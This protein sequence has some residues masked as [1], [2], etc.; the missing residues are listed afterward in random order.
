MKSDNNFG[1]SYVV[2]VLHLLFFQE[3][4]RAKL[5]KT[6][7][8]VDLDDWESVYKNLICFSFLFSQTVS[9][10]EFEN[11]WN[12]LRSKSLPNHKISTRDLKKILNKKCDTVPFYE[13]SNTLWFFTLQLIRAMVR[14]GRR[15]VFFLSREGEFLKVLFDDAVRQLGLDTY[16]NS[17]YLMVS[18]RAT[19]APSL[20]CIE[21]ETFE[22]FFRQY[23]NTS[24]YEFLLSLNFDEKELDV[25]GV[26]TDEG[27]KERIA[28]LNKSDAFKSILESS[29]FRRLYD[30]KRNSQK[31]YF[32][33]YLEAAGAN[34]YKKDLCIV[35]VGW[36]GTIQDNLY[37]ILGWSVQG[38]YLGI[39][40]A[41]QTDAVSKKQSLLFS[42]PHN[43]RY[44]PIYNQHRPI[45]EILLGASHG[46]VTSYTSDGALTQNHH[47]ESDLYRDVISHV[48]HE[49]RQRATELTNRICGSGISIDIL[50]REIA[51]A[52]GRAVLSPRLGDVE[53][54][55]K[56]TH[57]ENFGVF[58]FA[59]YSAPKLSFR[60][61]FRN[62]FV[63][64]SNPSAVLHSNI[65][66]ALALHDAGLK[67]FQVFYK[68]YILL[69]VRFNC[70]NRQLFKMSVFR[71]IFNSDKVVAEY[72]MCLKNQRNMIADRVRYI[73]ELQERRAS[74]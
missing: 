56:L 32:L 22:I 6:L 38:F 17:H 19:F 69:K 24:I 18:R 41:V 39:T 3:K 10:N 21:N 47:I 60:Q 25:L 29:E 50:E 44:A 68:M 12:G 1:F 9:K 54:Y 36:K 46:G 52:H 15:D 66:P 71:S 74:L 51:I 16:F 20:S 40:E 30:E 49:F 8:R 53:F 73:K 55:R 28:C 57:M 64:I 31:N 48:Q 33:S 23:S 34:F 65:W 35:D 43:S 63:L 61:R 26:L 13:V 7:K 5:E 2:N 14:N 27:Y 62:L 59:N 58:E 72:K 42:V 70:N 37:K 4:D 67:M 45:F 11:L